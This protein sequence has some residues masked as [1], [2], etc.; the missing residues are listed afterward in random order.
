VTPYE[1]H[2]AFRRWAA[3]G[4][5]ILLNGDVWSRLGREALRTGL[6]AQGEKHAEETDAHSPG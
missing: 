3:L 4:S 6:V 2:W 1:E 5:R